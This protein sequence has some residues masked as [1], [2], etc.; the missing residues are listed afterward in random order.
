MRPAVSAPPLAAVADNRVVACSSRD[1]S[2]GAGPDTY[3][4]AAAGAAGTAEPQSFAMSSADFP[5]LPGSRAPPKGSRGGGAEGGSSSAGRPGGAASTVGQVSGFASA[6]AAA[7]KAKR[8]DGSSRGMEQFGLLG[9]LHVIRMTDADLNT[10]ALGLDLT[11]LGL[12]LNSPECV[13]DCAWVWVFQGVL[14]CDLRCDVS[15]ACRCLYATFA[16]PWVD[17]PTTKDPQFT[18]PQCY[19]MQPPA[20]KTGHLSEFALETL[21]YIFYAMPQDSLQAYAAQELYKREWRYHRE[22]RLWFAKYPA[23]AE[24]PAGT[25]PPQFLYFD[26]NAWAKR[27]YTGTVLGLQAGFLTPADVQV[28]LV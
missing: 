14:A 5:A 27:A 10:L 21:F 3:R 26:I 9:L 20:L 25:T 2:G 16:S 8:G 18:L 24:V 1:Q 11:T 13:V 22:L 6:V 28:K 19:N 15:P 7:P 23:G 17:T 12:N 4:N